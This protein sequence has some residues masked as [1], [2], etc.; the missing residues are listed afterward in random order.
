MKKMEKMWGIDVSYHNGDID[1]K[2]VKK[3]GI[4]FAILRAGYSYT[5]DPKFTENARGCFN[6]NIPIGAYWFSYAMNKTAAKKEAQTCLGVIS[7]WKIDYPVCFDFEYDSLEYAKKHGVNL[8]SSEMAEI[9][10]TFLSEI[11]KA[12]YYAMNYSNP[13]FLNKGFNKLLNRYDLW[14]AR[15]S[16]ITEPGFNCGIWQYSSV[17]SVPGISGSVDLDVSFHNY[18]EIINKKKKKKEEQELSDKIRTKINEIK[19][20]LNELEGLIY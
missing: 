9:A 16:D 11:E 13:D 3:S 8:S 14:L 15:W 18:P 7:K 1:W 19:E 10:E 20:K 12:G 6:N 2:Q 4:Q 5:I 17:G